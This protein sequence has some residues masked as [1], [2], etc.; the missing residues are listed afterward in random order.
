VLLGCDSG[1]A[2]ESVASALRRL[3]LVPTLCCLLDAYGLV[4]SSVWLRLDQ[5]SHEGGEAVDGG[6]RIEWVVR[7]LRETA[8]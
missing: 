4:R 6:D 7:V 3:P 1:C 8:P 2:T 5:Q